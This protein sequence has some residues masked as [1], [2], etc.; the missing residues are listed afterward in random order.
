[1]NT[2]RVEFS[3]LSVLQRMQ[4][5]QMAFN[6]YQ[7]NNGEANEG[8][9]INSWRSRALRPIVRNKCISIAAH[10]TARLIFPKVFAQDKQSNDQQESAMIMEDLMEW[11]AEDSNYSNFSLRR[12]I[13]ALTDPV[14]IGYTEYC[15]VQREVK[16]TKVNGKWTKEKI[17]DETLSGFQDIV[18]PCDQLYIENFYEPDIQKQGWLLWRRVQ[19]YSLLK[20]KYEAAYDNFKYVKAGVQTIWS[21]ANQTFYYVYDSNMRQYEG[22]EIVYWNRELDVKLIVVNGVLLTDYD[23]PNPR[24]D[25]LYPFDIF[26]YELINNRCFYYKSLAYKMQQDANIVNTLYPMIIDGTYLS[27]MPPMVNAG[28]QIISSNVIIPGAVTNLDDPKANLQAI[29]LSQ[30]LKAGLDTLMEVNKSVEE[31]SATQV[32]EGQNQPGNTTAY[33][34]SRLE[35]NAATVLGLFIKMISQHVKDYGRLRIGDILQYLTVVD[36]DQITDNGELVYKTF[37]LRNKETNGASKTRQIKFDGSMPD[38]MTEDEKLDESYKNLEA[39][40]GHDSKVELYRANPVLFRNF[41]YT[42]S[43]SPDVLNPRSEDLERAF[44]TEEFDKAILA[45][46]SGVPVDLEQSYRDMIL[47]AYPKTKQDPDKY[48]KK[49]DLTNPMAQMQPQPGQQPQAPAMPG[50]MPQAPQ[51]PRPAQMSPMQKM[52]AMPQTPSVG[53]V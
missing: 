33:E 45:A 52:N 4:V 5:D 10:A 16:R 8:D 1:M 43:V 35:Q 25:K 46:Q 24:L 42:S 38:M 37:L 44:S 11:A 48:I 22:E 6:A 3:D 9:P 17:I 7:P 14:S 53:R 40:G 50:A 27:I 32:Q 28:G 23:N 12:T 26:G 18:V 47:G 34:I 20:A 41:K 19:P 31:D 21:D 13:A 36:A 15:E 2:P 39:Q 29:Q 49:P 30:N 51:A